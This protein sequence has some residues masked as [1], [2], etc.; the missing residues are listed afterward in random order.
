MPAPAETS[1]RF[2]LVGRIGSPHGV[3]GAVRL[4]SYTQEPAAIAQYRAL[5]DASHKRSIQIAS[6]RPAKA[7]SFIAEIRGVS[8]RDEAEALAGLD[9]YVS[10]AHLPP[11]ESDEFYV[12]DLIGLRV[13]DTSGVWIGSIIDVLDFGGGSILQIQAPGRPELLLPF[14]QK[15]VPL[16]DFLAGLVVVDPPA[17]TASVPDPLEQCS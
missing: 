17:F 15:S 5:C 16:I 13:N 7:N 12:F 10:R 1:D 11:L 6:L 14:N 2:L 3:R 8:T 4:T 9:L